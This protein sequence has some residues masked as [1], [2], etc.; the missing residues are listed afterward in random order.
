MDDVMTNQCDEDKVFDTI[1]PQFKPSPGTG[2]GATRTLLEHVHSNL[3]P[4]PI[5]NHV[6]TDPKG[7]FS[8]IVTNVAFDIIATQRRE[9]VTNHPA[10]GPVTNRIYAVWKPTLFPQHGDSGR[11]ASGAR[12]R[13]R[14]ACASL[15]PSCAA[16]AR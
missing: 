12:G 15:V 10:K 5:T 8:L 3:P 13:L 7:A 14:W 4:D 1:M 11:R 16:S 2:A 6:V 9:W